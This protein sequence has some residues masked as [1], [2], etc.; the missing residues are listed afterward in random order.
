MDFNGDG[1]IDHSTLI[2]LVSRGRVYYA[3]HS[4]SRKEQAASS[5]FNDYRRLVC[6]IVPVR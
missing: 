6:Y 1:W 3:A 4:N 2:S 5:A